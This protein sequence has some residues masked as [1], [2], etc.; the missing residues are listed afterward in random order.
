LFGFR[1]GFEWLKCE[2]EVINLLLKVRGVE[3]HE[4][5][6]PNNVSVVRYRHGPWGAGALWMLGLSFAA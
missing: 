6:A 1:E 3:G 4:A 5:Q 2:E